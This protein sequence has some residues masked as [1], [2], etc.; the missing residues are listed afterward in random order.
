MVSRKPR[1]L[2]TTT[3]LPRYEDD[4]EPRFVLDLTRNMQDRFETT[5][6]TPSFPG[7]RMREMI[8][9]VDII[10]YRYAPR[11]SWEQLA[12]PG[13][14]M[15]RLRAEPAHWLL[16]PGLIL[17]QALALRRML[18]ARRF[19]IIHAHW[20]LP[21]GLLAATL[22][23]RLQ[24]P[25]VTTAHGGDV[26]SLGR[27]ILTPLLRFVLK[28]AAAVTVVSEE[29]QLVL[30]QME[31]TVKN[32][33]HQIPMGVDFHHFSSVAASAARPDDM[34]QSGPVIISVGRLSEKKGI[35]V[36]IDALGLNLPELASTR[37]VIIGDGPLRS[38][39][40]E[41]AH[42]RGLSDRVHFLGARGHDC[43]PAYL[44]AADVFVLPCIEARDG[45]KDGLPVALME[46]AACGT[47]AIASN[48][49]GIPMFLADGQNGLLVPPGDAPALAASLAYMLRKNETRDAFA[50]AAVTTAQSFDWSVIADRYAALLL[51]TLDRIDSSDSN[52]E[53]PAP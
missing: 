13:G 45:D 9:G 27:H 51:N 22:P 19:D 41:R 32:K 47:P 35:H 39:L 21:Q 3:T 26:Y 6:L 34:S 24:V 8:C 46:A 49:G 25:F 28:R 36:L 52:P 17:G 30:S 44:A 11:Q 20:T 2:V 42:A 7:A 18:R 14:I 50:A 40:C 23:H 43:L 10:R 1:L 37:L 16:V 15:S 5:V 48:I 12:Y 29:L 38:E 33:I 4:S 31:S 53:R